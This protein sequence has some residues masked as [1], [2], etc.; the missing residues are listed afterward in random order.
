MSVFDTVK[1]TCLDARKA[2]NKA[3]STLLITLIGELEGQAKR[4]GVSVSNDMVYSACKKFISNN[5]DTIAVASAEMK[6]ALELENNTLTVF[7]PKQLDEVQLREVIKGL[8]ITNIGLI[9]KHLKENY[10]GRYDSR[11]ASDIAKSL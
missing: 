8:A 2:K 9:M 10:N 4:T 7:L 6:E 11:M 3:V 1:K 5:N